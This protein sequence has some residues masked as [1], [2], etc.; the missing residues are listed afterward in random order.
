MSSRL[1]IPNLYDRV[2]A[3]LSDQHE[4]RAICLLILT[5]II[6]L[7]LSETKNRLQSLAEAFRTVL[8]TKLSDNAVKTEIERLSEG[9]RR[10]MRAS[11]M[12]QRYLDAEDENRWRNVADRSAGAQQVAWHE[13][14]E[15]VR[16]NVST[17]LRA[18]EEELSKDRDWRLP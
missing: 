17:L 12:I 13:Y 18:A 6:T 4:V 11:I 16:K 14:W 5:K 1:L 7:G 10:I 8:S 3:G 2:I 15:W 9:Q